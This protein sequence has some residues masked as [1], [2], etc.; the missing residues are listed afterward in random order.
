MNI[1]IVTLLIAFYFAFFFASCKKEQYEGKNP[2]ADAKP[3]LELK[4]EASTTVK[5]VKIGSIVK[6]T[7]HGFEKYKDS[8]LVVKFN[9]VE[10]EVVSVSETVIEAKVPEAA[11][12]GIITLVVKRQVFPGST[13]RILGGLQVDSTFSEMPGAKGS[14]HSVESVPGGK[15]LLAGAFEDYGPIASPGGMKGIVRVTANG[16][17]DPGFSVG[18]GLAGS[19]NAVISQSNGKVIV[20]GS[21]NDFNER[22]SKNPLGN[23]IRLNADGSPDTVVIETDRGNRLS[24]P[25]L[26]LYFDGAVT[27]LLQ[28]PLDG[29]ITILGNFK[30]VMAKDFTLGTTDGTA[31]SVKIDS[32]RMEG[33]VR[34]NEDGS[35]DRT[36]NFNPATNSSGSGPN[37][38]ILSA[39][40][41]NDGKVVLAGD[42][43]RIN[44][45]QANR[46]VR[47]NKDGTIDETFRVG[48]GPDKRVQKV[49]LMPDG[50]YL[51]AGAFNNYNGSEVRKVAAVGKDGTLSTGFSVGSG[52][53]S[54]PDGLIGNAIILKTG[55]ILLTGSF[56][57]FSGVKR[58]G[59][60]V[61]ES[62]GEVSR[63]L[64]NLGALEAGRGLKGGV[65]QI[66]SVPGSDQILMAGSFDKIDLIPV[67]NIVKLKY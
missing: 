31:D 56:D 25:A 7:G 32:I 18:K 24:L 36:F 64:N 55:A 65:R 43:T 34:I 28:S 67:G 9:S 39:L 11:S 66:I 21:F 8:G 13:V 61:L 29:K 58:D 33:M 52:P 30:Y 4:L 51:I 46:L 14:I 19:G 48:S 53:L 45:K 2:Y 6:L 5:Q 27:H 10:G 37:G 50:S 15:F 1:K 44:D 62:N 57:N 38:Q 3:P 35:F 59:I 47:L 40:Q 17:V 49:L 42:F 20:A 22:F 41:Q 23:I 63:T 16:D 60:V 54:G 12:S 26:N